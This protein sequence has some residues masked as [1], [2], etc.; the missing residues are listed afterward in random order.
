MQLI[1][2]YRLTEVWLRCFWISFQFPPGA[3][4][5]SRWNFYGIGN[6]GNW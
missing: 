5:P 6:K 3:L 2:R 4:P 1:I